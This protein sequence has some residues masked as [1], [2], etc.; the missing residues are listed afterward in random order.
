MP[1]QVK[2][3]EAQE[4]QE[5]HQVRKLARSRHAPADWKVHAKTGVHELGRQ[6]AQRDRHRTRLP[7]ANGAHPP[8]AL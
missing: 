1:K 5:E 2:A 3:R 4:K 7:S 6:D 8:E